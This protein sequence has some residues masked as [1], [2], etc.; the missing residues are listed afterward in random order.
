M[1][2]KIPLQHYKSAKRLSSRLINVDDVDQNRYD[3]D[4]IRRSEY[5][6]MGSVDT[7]SLP[8][9][10]SYA[11]DSL[12]YVQ[13]FNIFHYQAPS[14]TDRESYNSW[15]VAYTYGGNGLLEYDGKRYVLEQNSGFFIDCRNH[16]R[17]SV[18]HGIWDVGILHL[19]GPQCAPLYSQFSS[20]GSVIFQTSTNGAF[21]QHLEQLLYI[22]S[23][24]HIYRDW[25]ASSAI[26]SLLTQILLLSAQNSSR[27]DIPDN[28]RYLLRYMESNFTQNLTLDRLSDFAGINKYSLSREFKKYT[29]FSPN[30]YLIQLRINAAK[31]LLVTTNM[32]AS[33]IA[34]EVGIHDINNFNNL[35]RKNTGMTPIQYRKLET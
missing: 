13:A 12:N 14:Y 20:A 31:K 2:D 7:L 34:L 9:I 24:P 28:I 25:Q 16:H 32:P 18:L 35:F 10:S 17:Y 22:Y 26:M 27:K 6:I 1:F 30:S 23:I 8:P 21:Q 4:S 33:C 29:G 11:K 15:L 19:H 5:S 3:T